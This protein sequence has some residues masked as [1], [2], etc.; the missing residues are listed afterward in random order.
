MYHRFIRF[1]TAIFYSVILSFFLQSFH[2]HVCTSSISI[3]IL[4]HKNIYKF[5]WDV[6]L[7]FYLCVL[8]WKLYFY[9]TPQLYL[10][11]KCFKN[12]R[13]LGSFTIYKTCLQ[14]FVVKYF[15]K[16]PTSQYSYL[17]KTESKSTMS[18][19]LAHRNMEWNQQSTAMCKSFAI[20]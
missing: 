17:I 7:L 12:T 3:Y 19:Y 18:N 11:K 15:A 6:I 16:C 9:V 4:T 5:H 14:S 10:I 20:S 1:A 8:S 2:F 13:T